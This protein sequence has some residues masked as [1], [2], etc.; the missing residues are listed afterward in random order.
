M[1]IWRST[2]SCLDSNCPDI[3]RSAVQQSPALTLH[4]YQKTKCKD[5]TR[6]VFSFR[7]VNISIGILKRQMWGQQEGFIKRAFQVVPFAVFIAEGIEAVAMTH[8]WSRMPI[9]LEQD[10]VNQK[11]RF[12]IRPDVGEA[13]LIPSC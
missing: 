3:A 13:G 1:T 10:R 6:C 12:E 9:P 2:V 8:G 5:I 11:R 4:H 7:L